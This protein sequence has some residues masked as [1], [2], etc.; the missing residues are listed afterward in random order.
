MKI[1]AKIEGATLFQMHGSRRIERGSY[2]GELTGQSEIF[3][4]CAAGVTTVEAK[5]ELQSLIENG[6]WKEAKQL[7]DLLEKGHDEVDLVVEDWNGSKVRYTPVGKEDDLTIKLEA[8][9]DG[10][11]PFHTEKEIYLSCYDGKHY[12]GAFVSVV[13]FN[14]E[15]PDWAKVWNS[16]EEEDKQAFIGLCGDNPEFEL[17]K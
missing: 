9:K 6:S 13:D 1:E 2:T 12:H 5:E 14:P 15:R 11:T 7:I 4:S 17:V 3:E 16:L 10:P 8:L